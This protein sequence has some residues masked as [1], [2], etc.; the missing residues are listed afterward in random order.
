M[1][2]EVMTKPESIHRSCEFCKKSLQGRNDKRF[3]DYSC[4][5]NYNNFLKRS[6]NKY[7]RNINNALGKNR[8][9]LKGLL[10]D[11][12]ETAKANEDRL[13]R[14]GFQ[15]NYFTNTY[16]TKN[17]KTYYYCYDYGYLPLDNNWYLVVKK[18]ED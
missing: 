17:D 8:R 5:N 3:C 11:G 4:R 14:L 12:V 13:K 1:F 16:T 15:F 18:S 7:I 2:L 6:G 10:K 9:I